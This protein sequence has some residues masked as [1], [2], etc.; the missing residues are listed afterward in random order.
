MYYIET[1][2]SPESRDDPSNFNDDTFHS[3]E[4]LGYADSIQGTLFVNIYLSVV[5][6]VC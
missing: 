1:R 5:Y 6:S 2:Y 3:D 4:Y